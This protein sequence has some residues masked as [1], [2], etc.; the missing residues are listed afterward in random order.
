MCLFEETAPWNSV[1]FSQ[2]QKNLTEFQGTLSFAY[3]FLKVCIE[4]EVTLIIKTLLKN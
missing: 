4:T 2:L 3:T 1:A